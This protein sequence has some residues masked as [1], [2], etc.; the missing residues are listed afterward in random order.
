MRLSVGTLL[1][2]ALWTVGAYGVGQAFRLVS[3]V[4]L[5][6]LLAP[7]L[8]GTMIIVNTIATGISLFSD[9][10]V[11]QNIIS[12]RNA[13]DPEYYNTAWSLQIIRGVA[14]F[15]VFVMAAVPV[16]RFY[17]TPIL[18]AIFPISAIG[19]FISGFTSVSPSLLQK[20]M[21]FPRLNLFTLAVAGA[22]SGILILV[23]YLNRTIWAL[24]VGGLVGTV[25]N[26]VGSHFLLR[27]VKPRFYLKKQYVLEI[28]NFGKW[29]FA[30]SI[31]Y[32]LSGNFDRLY[33]AKVVPLQLLGIYGIARSI[34]DL[35]GAVVVHLGNN[36]VFPFIA[37]HGNIPRE[38]LRQQL[39][40]IRWK[41]LSLAAFGCS[42]FI[43]T[44]DLAIRLLYDQR[45]HAA[46]W[47]LP[48][49]LI[50]AWFS[51]IASINE[52]TL[53]GLGRPSYSAAANT[54]RFILLAL[55]LPLGLK[56]SGLIGGIVTLALIE[57]CR[58][59]PIFMG[60]I[61]ERFSFGKQDLK[62]TVGMFILLGFWEWLRWALGFGTSFDTLLESLPK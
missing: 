1:H 59:F 12:S 26:T 33:L 57:V 16:A 49:L 5:A 40:S 29:I 10:G 14:L 34:S 23:T 43:A 50:G 22:S 41:F 61:R 47:M 25:L 44:A 9:I 6:R 45:Y 13:D 27:E 30:S 35:Q 21:D 28:V 7:E 17:D 62:I 53:L 4:I 36:V 60:Q 46:S 31:V 56:F 2:G 51:T 48:I 18:A 52:S 15:L 8:F 37:S 3:N 11:F 42:L 20:R 24:V 54:V 19:F 58:Y 38:S 39:R 55:V 32:F